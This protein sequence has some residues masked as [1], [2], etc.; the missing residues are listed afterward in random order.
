MLNLIYMYKWHVYSVYS[1]LML[2]LFRN[3]LSVLLWFCRF[4]LFQTIFK[5]ICSIL[6]FHGFNVKGA[7]FYF[8][9]HLFLYETIIF[10]TVVFMLNISVFLS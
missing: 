7:K 3:I 8:S 9:S 6:F 2:L 5:C 4:K 10:Y 1:L